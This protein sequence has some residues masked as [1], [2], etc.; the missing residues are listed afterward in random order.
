[1]SLKTWIRAA[2]R[3]F[4]EALQNQVDTI[5]RLMFLWRL[6][7]LVYIGLHIAHCQMDTGVKW[8]RGCEVASPE[9]TKETKT[10]SCPQHEDV[11]RGLK[12]PEWVLIIYGIGEWLSGK[13]TLYPFYTP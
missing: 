12:S 6:D 1:M 13:E 10:T 3:Q 4:G 11:P 7:S 2:G 8:L 5:N 9:E